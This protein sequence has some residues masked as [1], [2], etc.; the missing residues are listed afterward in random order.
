MESIQPRK[1][2]LFVVFFLVFAGAG[3][4]IYNYRKSSSPERKPELSVTKPGS[5]IELTEAQIVVEGKASK[6][7]K[8]KVNDKD[9]EVDKDGSFRSEV[10]LA[11]GVNI[12]TFE[13]SFN[14]GKTTKL[15]RRVTRK[16]AQKENETAVTPP[17][18]QARIVAPGSSLSTT[19]PE[20]FWIPE[21]IALSAAGTAWIASRRRFSKATKSS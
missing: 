7:S 21:A 6:D 20:N 11:E 4:G 5:D 10:S 16:I 18:T 15:D 1:I 14:G 13:A 19:G 9:V 17:P 8:V 12:I 2:I 3:L